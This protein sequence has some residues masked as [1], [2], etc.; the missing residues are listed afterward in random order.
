[1]ITAFGTVIYYRMLGV[2]ESGFVAEDVA[3]LEPNYRQSDVFTWSLDEFFDNFICNEENL[4][5]LFYYEN[6]EITKEKYGVLEI[7]NMYCFILALSMGG[8]ES[9]DEMIQ[10]DARV[11]LDLLLQMC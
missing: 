11:Q 7:D 1:M 5:Q 10:G 6:F 8:N 2:S 4:K 9:V 3:F